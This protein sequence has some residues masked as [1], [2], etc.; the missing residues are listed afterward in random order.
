MKG[1]ILMTNPFKAFVDDGGIIVASHSTRISYHYTDFKDGDFIK[2]R[3]G[4]VEDEID[5]VMIELATGVKFVFK[6]T[7]DPLGFAMDF[8]FD[9]LPIQ[10]VEE[11]NGTILN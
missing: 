3:V 9:G 8:I 10:V 5:I 4:D 6:D 1:D 7:E 11:Y 2:E